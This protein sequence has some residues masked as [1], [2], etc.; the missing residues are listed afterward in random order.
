V[1]RREFIAGLGGAAAWPL[2][3]R[4]QQTAMPVIGFL[5]STPSTALTKLPDLFRQGLSEVGFVEGRNVLV[6]HRYADNHLDRLPDLA[7]ELVNRPVNVIVANSLAAE[8][9]RALTKTIPIVF[10]TADDPVT[11][12]LV[13]SLSRPGA[14]LTGLT[15]FGGGLLG[16]K[17][18]ELLHELAPKASVVGFLMDPKWPGARQN[19]RMP[20]EQPVLLGKNSLWRK[21]QVQPSLSRHSRPLFIRDVKPS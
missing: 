13:V 6:E 20:K 19:C 9:A 1:K 10:V 2:L 8:A 11:R 17:R 15:F 12:G 21:R 18:V 14:N 4:A 3:A 7:A 5:G 16:A